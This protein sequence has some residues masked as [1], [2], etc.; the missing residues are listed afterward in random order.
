MARIHSFVRTVALVILVF[1]LIASG[2]QSVHAQTPIR[3]TIF[4]GLGPGM[5][6]REIPRELLLAKRWNDIHPDIF[7]QFDFGG[8]ALRTD[9]LEM[10]VAAGSPPDIVGPMDLK[11]L[12]TYQDF[13][14][15][16]SP[17]IEHDKAE[18]GLGQYEVSSLGLPRST[19]GKLC[20]LPSALFPSA[21]YVNE[22]MFASAGV[23]LPPLHW[24]APYTNITGKQ[25]PWDWDTLAEVARLLTLDTSR[26]HPGD[27][28]FDPGHIVQYG[29]SNSWI[30]MRDFAASW[31][32]PDA[33][34]SANG[35]ANFAQP[36]YVKAITWLHDGMFKTHFISSRRDEDY[37]LPL[38]FIRGDA[39]MYYGHLWFLYVMRSDVK[40]KWNVYAGP[41]IPGTDGTKIIAPIHADSMFTLVKGSKHLDVAWQVLKWLNTPEVT[42]ELADIFDDMPLARKP[43]QATWEQKIKK[44]YPTLHTGVFLEAI[45][46]L[47]IPNNE[48]YLP[49]G[50][51]AFYA[52]S[53]FDDKVRD[54]PEFDVP[55]ELAA[56]NVQMQ[57]LF[58][59]RSK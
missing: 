7:L 30:P 21:L 52:L 24:G 20:A 22:E 28:G 29:F 37:N 54:T 10:L 58:D 33:G 49:N 3:I 8:N 42:Q 13:W 46:Y 15:D 45:P 44:R 36:A 51:K 6:N 11:M 2:L 19:D 43:L 4:V 25:V 39:A 26:R 23:P 18:L 38:P 40:F 5:E 12:S 27:Q 14:V 56:L 53:E 35:K 55:A 50:L 48:S 31:G 59:D 57:A 32:S 34:L 16:L 9:V 47:D 17:Y 41:A 1:L